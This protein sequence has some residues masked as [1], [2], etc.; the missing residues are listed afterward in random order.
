MQNIKN[1]KSRMYVCVYAYSR[2]N[3]KVVLLGR[4]LGRERKREI[5]EG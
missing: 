1:Q 2:M 5:D 4:P 3:V